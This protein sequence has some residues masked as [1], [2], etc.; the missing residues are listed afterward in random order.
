MPVLLL[1]VIVVRGRL[2]EM[3]IPTS[4]QISLPAILACIIGACCA[5]YVAYSLV[6][7]LQLRAVWQVNG[8]IVFG[9]MLGD[10]I[11]HGLAH[12]P[13]FGDFWGGCFAGSVEATILWGALSGAKLVWSGEED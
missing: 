3:R 7:S 11:G 4:E 10:S 9:G 1:L 12:L 5:Y 13:A 6:T 8:L 2:L